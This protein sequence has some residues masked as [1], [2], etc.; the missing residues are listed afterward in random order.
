VLVLVRTVPVGSD[1][2]GFSDLDKRAAK[3]AV[4][5]ICELVEPVAGRRVA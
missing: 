1:A 4:D 5:L 3:A 2:A